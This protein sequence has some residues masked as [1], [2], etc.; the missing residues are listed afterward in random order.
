MVLELVSPVSLLVVLSNP[1]GGPI[2]QFGSSVSA[3]GVTIGSSA[4]G[5]T[6]DARVKRSGG[7]VGGS[8]ESII[9]V[10]PVGDIGVTVT[11]TSV[12][13]TTSEK[14]SDAAIVWLG[15]AEELI[16]DRTV[17]V[18][19]LEVEAD[20]MLEPEVIEIEMGG[21]T[22]AVVW[23]LLILFIKAEDVRLAVKL[24]V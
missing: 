6:R 7:N 11:V 21:E 4:T 23:L 15:T 3:T 24:V 5:M 9:V 17:D 8:A 16:V 1:S 12:V 10:G 2:V 18:R 20:W 22:D 14:L 19:E 13:T